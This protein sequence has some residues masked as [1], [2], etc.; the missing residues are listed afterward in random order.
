MG[1]VKQ[2]EQAEAGEPRK[3]S[4]LYEICPHC[5]GKGGSLSG[6]NMSMPCCKMLGVVETGATAG[7]LRYMADLDTLR[8]EAGLSAAMLRDGRARNMIQRSEAGKQL[9]EAMRK[10]AVHDDECE[11]QWQHESRQHVKEIALA[12]LAA[13]DKL[14]G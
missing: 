13:R 9:A 8:Q 7:Q 6:Q 3:Q 12:A 14:K 11:H 5:G 10:I 2:R 1:D 4:M